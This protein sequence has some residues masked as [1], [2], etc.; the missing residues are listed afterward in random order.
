MAVSW[1]H[2]GSHI[3]GS[4]FQHQTQKGIFWNPRKISKN[5]IRRIFAS[6][7]WSFSGLIWLL[8][9][10][11]VT[12]TNRKDVLAMSE[13]CQAIKMPKKLLS[14]SKWLHFWRTFRAKIRSNQGKSWP[15]ALGCF[16]GSWQFNIFMTLKSK[17]PFF[18]QKIV[19]RQQ[20]TILDTNSW[21]L[22]LIQVIF[23]TYVYC[24][25]QLKFKICVLSGH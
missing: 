22:Y 5:Q 18:L 21:Q 11:S 15:N 25:R 9:W 1:F 19:F 24:F 14:N 16:S 3:M 2:P 12:L 4:I 6:Q 23:E 10:N 17:Y 7:I 20:K 13:P 8:K